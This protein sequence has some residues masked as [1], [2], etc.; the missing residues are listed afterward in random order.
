MHVQ[1]RAR[2][3]P[4]GHG[5]RA[6]HAGARSVAGQGRQRISV[7]RVF[8]TY[9]LLEAHIVAA[10]LREHGIEAWAFDVD[11]VRLNWFEMLAFGGFRVVASDASV[12]DAAAL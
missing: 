3:G 9:D 10:L 6:Q 11:F 4:A 2:A 12:G 7:R 1:S 5:H 8:R